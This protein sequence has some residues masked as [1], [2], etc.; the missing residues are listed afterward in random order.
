MDV[1]KVSEYN[2]HDFI[3]V[4]KYTD[5]QLQERLA[6]IERKMA[7]IS[8]ANEAAFELM[9]KEK[10]VIMDEINERRMMQSL[11]ATKHIDLQ[12]INLTDDELS[13]KENEEKNRQQNNN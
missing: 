7:G 9:M 1:V 4:K 10:D 5:Q 12:P 6:M 13:R 11:E 3:T 8:P 2:M